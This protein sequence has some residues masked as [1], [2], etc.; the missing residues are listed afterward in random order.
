MSCRLQKCG[1]QVN[2]PKHGQT[3]I[4]AG[5]AFGHCAECAGTRLNLVT[6]PLGLPQSVFSKPRDI[7]SFTDPCLMAGDQQRCA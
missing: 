5:S 6:G 7:P 4:G 3:V 2:L 1:L